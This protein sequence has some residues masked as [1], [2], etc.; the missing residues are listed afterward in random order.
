M[1]AIEVK[2]K[3]AQDEY[4]KCQKI[5]QLAKDNLDLVHREL[6]LEVHFKSFEKLVAAANS[7]NESKQHFLYRLDSLKELVGLDGKTLPKAEDLIVLI[8]RQFDIK[9]IVINIGLRWDREDEAKWEQDGYYDH[10]YQCWRPTF[11]VSDD[12]YVDIVESSNMNF[13]RIPKILKNSLEC[14]KYDDY[15]QPIVIQILTLK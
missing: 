7:L 3:L 12:N 4:S 13:L 2:L 15:V 1:A 9:D 10:E 8:R 6:D 5:T 11:A 14:N